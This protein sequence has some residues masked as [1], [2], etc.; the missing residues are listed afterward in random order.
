MDHICASYII[1]LVVPLLKDG[2]SIGSFHAIQQGV[3]VVFSAANYD[4][5]PE[6]SLVRNVEPWSLCVAASSIDRNFPT[7]I[8]IGEIIFTR[9][10][11][12]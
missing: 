2:S 8:I 9:Y 1:V 5:S 4:V 7:K 12:I 10:N 6:P 3:T 11:A